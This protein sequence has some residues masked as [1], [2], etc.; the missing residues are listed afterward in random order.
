MTNIVY[1][2]LPPS[3]QPYEVSNASRYFSYFSF[4]LFWF[5]SGLVVG[6]LVF[7]IGVR[8]T[9]TCKPGTLSTASS[10]TPSLCHRAFLGVLASRRFNVDSFVGCRTEIRDLSYMCIV[11]G[12]QDGVVEQARWWL[13]DVVRSLLSSPCLLNLLPP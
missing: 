4:S 3:L 6:L 12:K 10:G 5:V 9:K 8:L 2:T 11:I 13:E 1:N 7:L